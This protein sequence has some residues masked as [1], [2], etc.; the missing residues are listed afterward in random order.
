MH[1][2]MTPANSSR[3]RKAPVRR[4]WVWEY[5]IEN[6]EDPTTLICYVCR[7]I[8]AVNGSST[9]E[10]IRH[11]NKQHKIYGTS[12]LDMLSSTNSHM[13]SDEEYDDEEDRTSNF[14]DSSLSSRKKTKV[15]RLLVEFFIQ[16]CLS[17]RVVESDTFKS[18]LNA[19]NSKYPP[20]SR[21]TL[22][23]SLLPKLV[24]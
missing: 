22:S 2:N 19:L 24:I 20:P 23:T 15:N 14:S 3:K 10:L 13:E 8:I 21:Q 7:N 17:F 1:N 6:E 4:S 12:E 11:L 5:F 16:S 9:T 18:L